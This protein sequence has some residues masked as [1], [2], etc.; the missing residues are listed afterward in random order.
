LAL[1]LISVNK[2]LT[3]YYLLHIILYSI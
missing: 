2:R 3:V 1:K